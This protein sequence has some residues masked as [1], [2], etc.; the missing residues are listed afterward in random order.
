MVPRQL[1]LIPSILNAQP[2]VCADATSM[3][4]NDSAAVLPR[5]DV[6]RNHAEICE[7]AKKQTTTNGAVS[8]F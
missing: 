2:N 7:T 1:T 5:T 3:F 6:V 8:L 4:L